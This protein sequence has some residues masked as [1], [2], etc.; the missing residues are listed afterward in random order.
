M[1]MHKMSGMM[2]VGIAGAMLA[3]CSVQAETL[4]WYRF[5]GDGATIE[6][7]ANPGTMDGVMKSIDTWGS[8]GGLGDTEAKFPTRCDAF[9][10]GTRLIDPATDAVHQ[11][12]V[13][14]LSFTGN[15]ANSGTVR[16]LKADTTAAFK[17]MM[18]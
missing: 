13:K 17:E 11:E 10:A 1:N 3:A 7:K 9:P 12:T 15:P 16:L 2:V 4:L 14:S 5:D 8:L 18:S 6:N